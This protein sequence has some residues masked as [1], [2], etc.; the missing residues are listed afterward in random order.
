MRSHQWYP[1]HLTRCGKSL[2][3]C[4]VLGGLIAVPGRGDFNPPVISVNEAPTQRQV[5]ADVGWFDPIDGHM[6]DADDDVDGAEAGTWFSRTVRAEGPSDLKA[7]ARQ[8]SHVDRFAIHVEADVHGKTTAEGQHM[9]AHS[10]TYVTFSVPVEASFN[11][12]AK[13]DFS[14]ATDIGQVA[15]P[16]L[17]SGDGLCGGFLSPTFDDPD[18][19]EIECIGTAVAGGSITFV[20]NV[21]TAIG[22]G[23][24]RETNASV[25]FDLNFGDR[26]HDDL[27][28]V[29]EEEGIDLEEFGSIPLHEM[30]LDA[31]PDIKDLYIEIDTL[32]TTPYFRGDL[33]QLVEVFKNAPVKGSDNLSGD[34]GIRLHLIHSE[35]GIPHPPMQGTKAEIWGQVSNIRDNYFGSPGDSAELRLAKAYVF[36]YALIAHQ[37][38][39]P[40]GTLIYGFG[41]GRSF[42][43]GLLVAAGSIYRTAT[44]PCGSSSE[45]C[46]LGIEDSISGAFMHYLG[47]T[48]GLLHGGQD[49]D[50]AKPN[51]L[52]AVSYPHTFPW[53][54]TTTAGTNAAQYWKLDYSRET[55]PTLD[56]NALSEESG[57]ASVT[58][59][60]IVFSS[61][62]PSGCTSR[63][64][65]TFTPGDGSPIDWSLNGSI[66]EPLVQS[67]ANRT[68]A[69]NP[70]EYSVLVG[71]S[72]W[73]QIRYGPGDWL[74]VSSGSRSSD[75][76]TVEEALADEFSLDD[77]VAFHDADWFDHTNVVQADLSV[78]KDN[79]ATTMTAGT[80]TTY[81][82]AV[83]NTG[84]SGVVGA[85]VKDFLPQGLECSWTCTPA[86][87]ATCTA[88]PV[89][90]DLIDTVDLP[91]GA[92]ATYTVEC[93]VDPDAIGPLTNLARVIPPPSVADL[94]PVDNEAADT[95]DVQGTCGHPNGIVL[96]QMIVDATVEVNAC[97]IVILGDQ[98]EVVS[99]GQL[100]VGTPGR[101]EIRSG[102]SVGAGAELRVGGISPP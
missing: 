50:E 55:L 99:P 17:P 60:P 101:V 46:W 28:D 7:S 96:D 19:W 67:D 76:L 75:S 39:E 14:D 49:D 56:E 61:S 23:I 83:D 33:D 85:T 2:L 27:L 98:L 57:L 35:S 30:E 102:F 40:D 92:S 94:D 43:N 54:T 4:T 6:T 73:D 53:N 68:G 78:T 13:F 26:D 48:L 11:F 97:S 62:V 41:E 74:V 12:K 86:N 25:E 93:L 10:S 58:G 15:F 31:D 45:P 88:G 47:H 79:G 63:T 81:T 90:G 89:E 59:R 21:A 1:R 80:M 8:K 100:I 38:K 9:S 42:G 64:C 70:L 95:D 66:E 51:Y 87:G 82:V 37:A 3:V 44:E 18:S 34:Q 36:R 29:W 71:H 84:P 52:S 22:D 65:R 32:A 5:H 72:D 16:T 77:V 69:S 20:V 91:V 24:P